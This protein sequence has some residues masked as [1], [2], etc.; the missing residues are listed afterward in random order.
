MSE[1]DDARPDDVERARELAAGYALGSLSAEERVHYERLL[2]VSEDAAREREQFGA[3]AAA[4]NAAPPSAQ[5]PSDLKARLMAR[6]AVTQQQPAPAAAEPTPTPAERRAVARWYR[7]PVAIVVAAAAAVVI[8]VG[9]A[10]VGFSVSQRSAVSAQADALAQITSAPD[11]QR[12]SRSV[13][14]GG[15]ATLVWS[16][17]LGKSAMIVDG[18]GPAPDGH[19]YQLW[20]MRGGVATS[21]GVMS[22]GWQVLTGELHKGDT[23]GLTI[24]PRGG[25]RQPTT[26]PVVTIVS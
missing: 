26:K 23:V 10:A 16:V 18:V 17:S 7:R 13:E 19:T 2:E 9:G 6:I 25:S 8:F 3:V 12:T 5:P 20:Y 1:R 22:G 15:T 24:E 14:G 21:A 11:V 4:L